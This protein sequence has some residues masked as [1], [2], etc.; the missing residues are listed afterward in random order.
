MNAALRSILRDLPKASPMRLAFPKPSQLRRKHE[1]IKVFPC[2]REVCSASKAGQLEYQRRTELMYE[3]DNGVCCICHQLI[4]VTEYPTFEHKDGRGMGG[5]RRDDR[6]E[7]NGV[8]HWE[9]NSEKGS[10]RLME[11]GS[12]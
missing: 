12:L 10:R 3:R 6:I 5:A 4:D 8:A 7:N 2:G 9:C 11:G 1:A